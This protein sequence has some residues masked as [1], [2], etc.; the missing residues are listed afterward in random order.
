MNLHHPLISAQ[1]LS[2]Q[3]HSQALLSLL[4]AH[5]IAAEL[6]RPPWDLALQLSSLHDLGVSDSHL[7]YLIC[8]EL[9]EHRFETGSADQDKR[10]FSAAG[11][12][13]FTADSCF[14]LTTTGLLA[15]KRLTRPNGA[16]DPAVHATQMP[17]YDTAKRILFFAGEIV[18]QFRVPAE[19]QELILMAFE[20]EE[21]PPHLTDPLP[22]KAETPAKRRLSDA[23]RNLNANQHHRRIRFRGDG[24]GSGV[25]W[26]PLP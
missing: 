23:I 6:K 13:R 7:R 20:E 9:V 26:E 24:R 17:H 4:E 2:A 19:N 5:E 12:L 11:F 10:T 21:W 3:E 15:A 14:V 8:Q 16:R 1:I 22:G 18:K 25:V